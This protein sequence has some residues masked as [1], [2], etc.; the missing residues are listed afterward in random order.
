MIFT[1][2]EKKKKL[3]AELKV[4]FAEEKKFP[5]YIAIVKI[6][7]LL[8]DL[9]SFHS[10]EILDGAVKRLEA[11]TAMKDEYLSISKQLSG[12]HHH[13]L[14]EKAQEELINRQ[15]RILEIGKGE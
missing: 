10:Q 2:K 14:S 3:I 9:L 4:D 5:H 12:P 11:I 13:L 8:N 15:N 1:F 6:L 7:N